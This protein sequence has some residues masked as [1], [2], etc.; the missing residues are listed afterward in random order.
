MLIVCITPIWS[1]APVLNK[2]VEA[3]KGGKFKYKKS[4]LGSMTRSSKR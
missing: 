2:A 1:D 3:L 4:Y